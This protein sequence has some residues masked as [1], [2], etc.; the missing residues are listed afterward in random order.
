MTSLR[1]QTSEILKNYRNMNPR[2]IVEY[3]YENNYDEESKFLYNSLP[4][5]FQK[6]LDSSADDWIDEIQKQND[7]I[8]KQRDEIQKQNDA[9][10]KQRDEIQKQ[11]DEIQKQRDEIQKQN[12]AIQKQRDEIQKQR[13]EIQKQIGEC[14]HRTRI[15]E[16][17]NEEVLRRIELNRIEMHQL[18]MI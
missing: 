5:D 12:D 18:G 17:L 8:Q 1:L 10:Q 13:D 9:I 11:R 15:T 14:R 4:E 2:S 6:V 3:L 16:A 7:A